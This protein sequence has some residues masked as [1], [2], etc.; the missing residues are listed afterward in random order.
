MLPEGFRIAMVDSWHGGVSLVEGGAAVME[1]RWS[2]PVAELTDELRGHADLIVYGFIKRGSLVSSARLGDSL[3][4]DWPPWADITLLKAEVRGAALQ[5]EY[6]PDAFRVQLLG[7]GYTGRAPKGEAW[8]TEPAGEAAALLQHTDLA[9]WFGAHFFPE[10]YTQ[11]RGAP[12]RPSRAGRGTGAACAHHVHQSRGR[13]RQQE[14][15]RRKLSV[16]FSRI[17]RSLYRGQD[18]EPFSFAANCAASPPRGASGRCTLPPEILGGRCRRRTC[19]SCVASWWATWKP[20]SDTR[21]RTSCGTRLR[22]PRAGARRRSG[23]L[24]PLEERMGGVRDSPRG[25]LGHRRSRPGDASHAR[26]WSRKRS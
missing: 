13:H 7:P 6:A 17:G 26:A 5:D 10:D 2:G 21:I 24:G 20:R 19:R 22:S 1:D 9:A 11:R 3:T 8:R 12:P 14:R 15:T 18:D 4:H 16:G 25:V 23:Q